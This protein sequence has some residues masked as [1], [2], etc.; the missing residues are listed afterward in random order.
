MCAIFDARSGGDSIQPARV[1][2]ENSTFQLV[3]P[4][5]F[6]ELPYTVRKRALGVRKSRGK[7]DLLGELTDHRTGYRFLGSMDA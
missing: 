4:R 2:P 1:V 3:V 5:H 6:Q 7:D